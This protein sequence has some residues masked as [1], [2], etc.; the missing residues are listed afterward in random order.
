MPV[1]K[2]QHTTSIPNPTTA[3]PSSPQE[4]V[5]QAFHQHLREQIRSAV[6]IVMEEVMREEL[7]QFL[8]AQWGECSP[9]RKGYRNG[10]YTR[11]LATA[12]GKIED[13]Q[14]PRDREGQFHTQ[15]FDR[16]SRYEEQVADGL[17]E[18]FVSGTST[19]KVGEVAET[20][21]GIAPS[22]SSVSRLNQTL[23]EQFEAW[24]S[25]RLQGHWRVLYLDGIYFEVRHGDKVD[26][27][28]VLAAL[29]VDLEGNKDILAIRACAQESQD[30]WMCLLQDLRTRGVTE[31]DLI[32]TDGHEGLLAAVSALFTAT[33]RQRCLVH[34]QR[35]VMNAIPKR[36]RDPIATELSGIWNQP[37]KEKAQTEL[38]AFKG[39]YRER[40]P[41]AVRSLCEDEEHLLTFYDFPPSMH[42]HIRST[43][44]IES[45][46]RNVRRRTDQIDT[47]TTETSCL[48]IVW[49][50]MQGIHLSTIPVS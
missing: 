9:Q 16:Y 11:D 27:T 8:R 15:I 30:G 12:S 6:Q 25:R 14:V 39:K 34:K 2:K 44:P 47:F 43:N 42:R 1:D 23:T 45:F 5:Q 40:Y 13:L 19:Q 37:T 18:M 36:E 26:P 31:V 7:T 20:L 4:L 29:G 33:P 50:V 35:N 41:E 32:L 28:V 21:M 24:R 48:S 3:E 46:F 38:A 17:T 22:K 49:A 10:S